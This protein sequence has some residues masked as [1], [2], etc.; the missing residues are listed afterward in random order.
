M[1]RWETGTAESLPV[2]DGAVTVAL[3]VATVHHWPDV[4]GAL[5]EVLRVLRP[6]GRFLTVE[7]AVAA[8]ATGL[9]SHGWTEAQAKAFA[10]LCR[11]AHFTEVRVD[12]HA[13]GRFT[14]W[15][16]HAVRP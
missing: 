12:R 10:N 15:A 1:I 5:P 3:A 14:M 7:R 6:G 8:D 4:A 9:G 16:V 13:M 11:A 2:S